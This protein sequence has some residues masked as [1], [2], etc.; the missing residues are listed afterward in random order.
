VFSAVAEASGFVIGSLISGWQMAAS[1]LTAI[2]DG[3]SAAVTT[4]YDGVKAVV[5]AFVDWLADKIGWVFSA[6]DKVKSAA[7]SIGD[8][9]GSTWNNALA[10]AGIDR[11]GEEQERDRRQGGAGAQRDTAR[12]PADQRATP[13]AFSDVMPRDQGTSYTDTNGTQRN[14]PAAPY[15]PA[16]AVPASRSATVSQSSTINAPITINGA[17]DPAET[18]RVVRAELDRRQ[19]ESRAEQRGAMVDAMGY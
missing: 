1:M 15:T 19:R 12:M 6:V 5:G 3:I 10:F 17:S 18:A 13:N 9:V 4:A 8:R 14:Q 11:S 16:A 7:G 2:W